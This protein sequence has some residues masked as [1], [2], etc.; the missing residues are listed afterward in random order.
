M[1]GVEF[2]RAGKTPLQ[3]YKLWPAVGLR[4]CGDI[5][6][7]FQDIASFSDTIFSGHTWDIFLLSSAVV[8]QPNS[9]GIVIYCCYY[10]RWYLT[11]VW[12]FCLQEF[13]FLFALLPDLLVPLFEQSDTQSSRLCDKEIEEI[14][15]KTILLLHEN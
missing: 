5:S 1:D 2:Q 7:L 12:R 13:I 14:I 4:R 3:V 11:S 6:I 8:I 9:Q 10:C 15:W